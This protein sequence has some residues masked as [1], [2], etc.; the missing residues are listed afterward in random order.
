MGQRKLDDG[1]RPRISVS[2]DPED[3]DWIQSLDGA[4]E[5]YTVS[6]IIRAARLAGLTLNDSMNGGVIE[7]FRDWLEAKRKKTK[8]EVELA[9][10]L[11]EFLEKQQRGR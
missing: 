4:S 1:K 6:R 8:L 3:Y 5:S 11:S 2:L 9:E 10:L 7:E